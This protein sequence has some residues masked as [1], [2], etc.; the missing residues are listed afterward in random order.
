MLSKDEILETISMISSQH[1]DVRTITMGISL[2][3]CIGDTARETCERVYKK[4]FDCDTAV[5][6]IR[7]GECGVFNPEMLE[8]F[9]EA[10]KDLRVFYS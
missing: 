10:E 3:D 6:M 9:E 8:Y 2:L 5:R 4:A 7:N 1:L